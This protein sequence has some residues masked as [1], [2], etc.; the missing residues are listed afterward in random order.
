MCTFASV[1]NGREKVGDQ[2]R[3][4]PRSLFQINMKLFCRTF[5]FAALMGSALVISKT[6]AFAQK[7]GETAIESRQYNTVVT[8]V[9]SLQIT[10]SGRAGGMG[11]VGVSTTPDVYSQY[12]N[13]SKY[14][15]LSSKAGVGLSYTP[16]L[17]A[18]VKDIKLMELVGY[19][20]LGAEDNHAL[21]A[22]IRYFSLGSVKEFND[23]GTSIGVAHPNEYAIDFGYSVRLSPN[24]SMAVALRYIRSDQNLSSQTESRAGNAF[25]ADIAGYY[26]RFFFLGNSEAL[27]TLGYNIKNIGTKISYGSGP[28]QFIPANLG[29]GTSLLYPIDDY[30]DISASVELNKLLVPTPP[31]RDQK[32]PEGSAQR[33]EKYLNTSSI[34]GIFKSFADAPGGFKEEMQE[35]SWGVGLE[36]SYNN[37]FFL[38]AGYH[39]QNPY[40]GNLQF[41]TVGAGFKMS[42]FTIDASY[43]ASTRMLNPLDKTLR[44]TLAFDL[45]GIRNLIR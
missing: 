6:A 38:R 3:T 20:K 18:L 34:A 44:F 32:D 21:S 42:V 2:K 43:L 17:A 37:R 9:P 12:F 13:P 11:D 26:T 15:M 28:S 16:W 40:K 8:S 41:F 10:P 27:W 4:N 30:N 14:A 7:E 24:Y 29:I 45:D 5:V 36:Y 31:L 33:Q 35:I 19:Y 39:Y 22:S 1:E 25:A 23:L